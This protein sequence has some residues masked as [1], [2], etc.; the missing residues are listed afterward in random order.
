MGVLSSRGKCGPMRTICLASWLLWLAACSTIPLQ[1]EAKLEPVPVATESAQPAAPPPQ[2]TGPPQIQVAI[3][4]PDDDADALARHWQALL[5]TSDDAL[6]SNDV[7][8]YIDILEGRLIQ[9]GR[10]NSVSVTRKGNTFTLLITGS[11]AF[12]SNRSRLKPEVRD[13]L[14]SI[15][16][17]LEEY[18]NILISI[19]GHTDSAGDARYNQ[20][21]SEW[22]AQ[23]VARYLIDGGV[24]AKRMAIIGYGETRPS[25]TNETAEGRSR[26]R[27]V[28]LLL[29]PLAK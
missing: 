10:D 2:S 20:R 9:Q 3:L 6:N 13:S 4:D 16:G 11:E 1:T 8:Y 24:A 7:G 27:R 18:R 14:A 15:T 21:L 23:S 28:E 17:I 5:E 12:D 25:A 26:N 19:F 29:A 22:R